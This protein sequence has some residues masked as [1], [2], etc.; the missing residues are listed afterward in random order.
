VHHIVWPQRQQI[1]SVAD[2]FLGDDLRYTDDV[3]DDL[4]AL[5]E[6]HR[7]KALGW[8][9]RIVAEHS[10]DDL[11][12]RA[13]AV[14]D[15]DVPRMNHIAD[16][17]DID[18]LCHCRLPERSAGSSR[19]APRTMVALQSAKF[20][21]DPDEMQMKVRS[22]GPIRATILH[23]EVAIAIDELPHPRRLLPLSQ[24]HVVL[25]REAPFRNK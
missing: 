7:R 25:C 10:H 4:L 6:G 1:R 3:L 22:D 21:L 9:G 16:H 23:Y 18:D 15:I 11:A 19:V 12:E 2:A 20:R 8:R 24:C 17:A 5:R 13:G 14:D